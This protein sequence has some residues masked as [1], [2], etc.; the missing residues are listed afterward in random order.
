MHVC[1]N[2]LSLSPILVCVC[3]CVCVHVCVCMCVCLPS[4]D[5][6]QKINAQ[7]GRLLQ[8][9][10]VCV[11]VC[12]CVCVHI[13][14]QVSEVVTCPQILNW[15]VQICLALKHVH[16]RKILH[17]DIKTQVCLQLAL[18]PP[19]NPPMHISEYLPHKV[20]NSQTWRFWHR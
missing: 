7:R 11:C 4:G 12:V 14:V 1:G 6:Y 17:R 5:L 16:D 20:W 13:S 9:E 10:Q 19:T 15:F 8:E 3:V 2:Y 18:Q